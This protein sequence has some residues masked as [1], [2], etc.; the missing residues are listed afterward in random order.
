MAKVKP[1]KTLGTA[2]VG[3]FSKRSANARTNTYR[4]LKSYR[5]DLKAYLLISRISIAR[6]AADRPA[7]KSLPRA[8]VMINSRWNKLQE[9][10][11]LADSLPAK[12]PCEHLIDLNGDYFQSAG[13]EKVFGAV[14]A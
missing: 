5:D 1:G 10:R 4:Y 12:I 2:R 11:R 6:S 7:T 8:L 3:L 13:P 14:I 9:A